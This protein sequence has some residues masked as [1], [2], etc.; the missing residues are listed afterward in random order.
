MDLWG[1]ASM[2][3]FSATAPTVF[4]FSYNSMTFGSAVKE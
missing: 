2:I 1:A 3:Q 4:T